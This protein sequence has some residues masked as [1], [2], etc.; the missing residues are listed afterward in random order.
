MMVVM[1]RRALDVMMVMYWLARGA[2]WEAS[3]SPVEWG[4]GV[5]RWNVIVWLVVMMVVMMTMMG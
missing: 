1:V 4:G 3:L 5:G 2:L